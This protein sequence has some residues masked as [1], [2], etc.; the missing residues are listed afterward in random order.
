MARTCA[1]T[2]AT[3]HDRAGKRPLVER[4]AG[5]G[6]RDR[7][8]LLAGCHGGGGRGGPL[9]EV[10]RNSLVFDAGRS[11][12]AKFGASTIAYGWWEARPWNPPT[13]N[14]S[15]PANWWQPGRRFEP[16]L[17]GPFRWDG[18]PLIRPTGVSVRRPPDGRGAA[19]GGVAARAAAGGG[20]GTATV[21]R[22]PAVPSHRASMR[23]SGGKYLVDGGWVARRLV[24][25]A[26]KMRPPDGNTSRPEGAVPV[27]VPDRVCPVGV[28]RAQRGSGPS[29]TPRGNLGGIQA[30][31]GR[32]EAL[33]AP[34]RAEVRRG[35]ALAEANP[36]DSGVE[37][38]FGKAVSE[39]LRR[40]QLSAQQRGST[41]SLSRYGSSSAPASRGL[42]N[43]QLPARVEQPQPVA[44]RLE[45]RYPPWAPVTA[46]HSV[47]LHAAP[48]PWPHGGEI[49]PRPAGACAYR[50]LTAQAWAVTT[51]RYGRYTSLRCPANRI[52]T[53]MVAWSICAMT[54]Y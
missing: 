9:H 39:P 33:S 20:M 21:G 44:L 50:L 28:T 37:R 51:C 38:P 41:L 45:L 42:Q 1:G 46:G 25:H 18:H 32:R 29:P 5:S 35:S 34:L 30:P 52:E 53:V 14:P 22:I 48:A 47:D 24:S 49:A 8:G 10:G 26:P 12:R 16:V 23:P 15:A 43:C 54:R 13:G 7:S 19:R 36:D 11:T 3:D 6:D 17:R 4:L 40:S 27:L 31:V 2:A